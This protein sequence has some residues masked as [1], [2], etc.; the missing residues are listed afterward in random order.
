MDDVRYDRSQGDAVA[1][2]S[3]KLQVRW[4]L[5]Q[6]LAASGMVPDRKP[7]AVMA[8]MLKAF[9][10]NIPT[11]QAMASL[12]FINGK[13]GMEAKLMDALAVKN[14][15]IRKKIHRSDDEVADIEFFRDGWD[16][17]RVVF[18][19]EEA[20]TAGLV[21]DHLKPD[22]AWKRWRPDMLYARALARGLRRIAPDYFS[23]TLIDDELGEIA[24]LAKMA[25][26]SSTN[27]DLDALKHGVDPDPA[28]ITPEEQEQ[29]DRELT[30]A[31][32]VGVINAENRRAIMDDVVNGHWIAARAAWD[33]LRSEMLAR[34][35]DQK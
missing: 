22:S 6:V 20:R 10:L 18:T 4:W 26:R 24:E 8:K 5:A 3:Q 25:A 29:L 2:F 35:P 28:I 16:S 13:V 30:E 15:G 21:T 33:A 9:E 34:E 11:M 12:T 7:E 32:R 31:E 14:C 19:V 17:V 27:E 1:Q 23:G